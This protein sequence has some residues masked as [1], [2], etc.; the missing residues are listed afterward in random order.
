MTASEA[1][2]HPWLTTELP[3]PCPPS[4]MPRFHKKGEEV[5]EGGEG[6]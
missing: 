4:D 1:L 5:E 6:V 3:L 2:T